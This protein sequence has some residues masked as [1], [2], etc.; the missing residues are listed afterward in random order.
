MRKGNA[1]ESLPDL[2]VPST[3]LGIGCIRCIRTCRLGGRRRRT[4][5]LGCC[6]RRGGRRCG[7]RCGGR[8]W[9]WRWR[10]WCSRGCTTCRGLIDGGATKKNVP[11]LILHAGC[12][13]TL[14]RVP[15]N[16]AL[17]AREVWAK[18]MPRSAGTIS[19][20]NGCCA[21]LA[22]CLAGPF[23]STH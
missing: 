6:G 22:C 12:R 10:R 15:M 5:R 16:A 19:G 11:G 13:L 8:R 1:Q 2:R 4:R 23:R 17:G 20:F 18:A 7:G 14:M 21:F 3:V 9:R